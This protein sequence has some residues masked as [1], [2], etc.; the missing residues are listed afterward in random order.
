MAKQVLSGL[1]IAAIILCITSVAFSGNPG[2]KERTPITSR[3]NP[4]QKLSPTPIA[5]QAIS[6]PPD[7]QQLPANVTLYTPP[8]YCEFTDYSGGEF[9]HYA[10]LPDPDIDYYNMR[11]TAAANYT[12]TL[13]TAY[14]AVFPTDFVGNPDLVVKV[15]EDDGFGLPGGELASVTVPYEN[16]PA[17]IGYAIADLSSFNLVFADGENY[18]V[19]ISTSDPSGAN[20]LALLLDDGNNGHGRSGWYDKSSGAFINLADNGFYDYNWGI[21]VDYCCADIPY[22][23]CYRQEY[24]CGPSAYFQHP[25]PYGTDY[26][27]TRFS[28]YGPDTLTALGVALYA[29]G[30]TGSPDVDIFVW[31]S[32][33]GFPD[34]SN[35]IYQTMVPNADI[36]YYPSYNHIDMPGTGLLLP[37]ASDFHIGWETVA[38][39]PGDT[40]A[41]LMDDGTCG[42]FRSSLRYQGAWHLNIDVLENDNNWLIYADICRAIPSSCVRIRNYCDPYYVYSMPSASGDGRIGGF[43][44][45]EPIGDGCHIYDV[46]VAIDNPVYYGYPAGFNFSTTI[47]IREDAGGQPGSVVADTTLQP[48]ELVEYPG[49]IYWEFI[50]ESMS[51]DSPLWVGIKSNAPDP[52]VVNQPDF[53][54][55]G[56]DGSCGGNNAYAYYADG[57][58][59]N[60]SGSNF[61]INA[62]ICCV[63]NPPPV[64]GPADPNWPTAAHDF[65][66]SSAS[67]NSVG[68]ARCRQALAWMHT[69]AA[70]FRYTRP[71]IY[72]GIVLAAYNEKLQAFDI[73]DGALLWTIAGALNGIGA[74]FQNTVTVKDGYVYYGGG[75]ARSISKADVY[76][77]QLIWTRNPIYL[78]HLTGSTINT[79][80][81]LLDCDGTEVLYVT[82]ANGAVY[83][84]DALTG[85]N[86]TGWP[87][88]PVML[89]GDPRQTLSSNGS[90][91]IYAG[92]DGLLG[93]GNG[94]L[95]AIDACTGAIL[96][97]LGE[98]DLAGSYLT[99]TD[100]PGEAFYGPIGVDQDGSIYVQSGFWNDDNNSTPSGA[101]YRITPDGSVFWA[102]AGRL[103]YYAGPV[104]DVNAVYFTTIRY[105]TGE[106]N[107]TAALRK[108]TGAK[109]WESDSF[110]DG[111]GFLE[112]ALSCEVLSPNWLYVTNRSRQMLVINSDDGSVEFEYNYAGGAGPNGCGVAIDSTHVV[113]NN[114]NGDLFCLTIQ[115][116]RPRL[117]ILKFDEYQPVPFFSPASFLVE[118]D[119]IFMNNGCANLTGYVTVDEN[120]PA[121]YAWS[122]DPGRISRM[123]TLASSMVDNT[124]ESVA[125]HL[126]KAQK[127]PA[128][129]LNPDFTASA[130]A[131]DSYSKTAAYGP[132]IWLNAVVTPYFDVAPGGTYSLLYD[133]NGPLVTQGPHRAYLS[134]HSNDQFFLNA[135]DAPVVQ[136]GVIGGCMESDD[137]LYFG[138]GETNQAPVFSTGELGNRNGSCLWGF[139]GDNARYWQGGL[140][141]AAE[142][143]DGHRLAWTTDSWHPADPPD[144]WN[145][146]LPEP[147][148][149][150]RCEPYVTIDPIVLGK[151]SH[152]GGHSY[153]NVYGY[154]SVAA[155]IDSVINFDCYGTGWDWSNVECPYDND[156]TIGLRVRQSM[157]GVIDE[158]ALAN[159][160]IF[161]HDVTNRNASPIVNVGIGAFN[162]YDMSS[163]Y[164]VSDCWLFDSDYSISRGASS[165]AA[166][167][168]TNGAVW[169]NG[170]IPMGVDPMLGATTIDAQQ[171]MWQTDNVWLDSVYYYLSTVRGQTAQIGIDIA[172]PSTTES[173]DRDEWSGYVFRDFAANETYSFGT[174]MFGFA[175]VDVTDHA[176]FRNLA[177]TVNRFAGFDRGDIDNDGAITLADVVA[178]WNMVN[179]GGPG[180]L[181]LHLA[182]VDA[183]GGAPNAADV[184][185]LANF[186]FCSGPAPA[187]DWVLPDICP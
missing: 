183:S 126:V 120:P 142:G 42:T 158:P 13:L 72:D 46:R 118:F 137:I 77:G 18:Y 26:Y 80:A 132:P 113:F 160:V 87:V 107:A 67:Y 7:I 57:S 37:P 52:Y 173:D 84:L 36:Q 53:F 112:G 23:Q 121:A 41:G 90:S 58:W 136:M 43:E 29:D 146:L 85:Q 1:F 94:T 162:D 150:N 168:F 74:D 27:N 116:D 71:I 147:N 186:Y 145:S 151:I 79:T 91:V 66:R 14:V 171:S 148:C 20:V 155:Y 88:N 6:R 175:G 130:Y 166:Y 39:A 12:C 21:G 184:L 56:D 134:I 3:I 140:F 179:A 164:N 108:S 167:D 123:S 156:L 24:D 5:Q 92:T 159:V 16:L 138:S 180:P 10:T 68:D 122:V 169:G 144:F 55:I 187:G 51:F 115:A 133:V 38:N 98:G 114:Y 165:S 70:R 76:T 104:I 47:E 63:Y 28:I 49:F 35:V 128:S 129:E 139:D 127:V 131:K 96:W 45:I 117:R 185:Y 8:Y 48:G 100:N 81:V 83:A 32:S 22:S 103:P 75:S 141:F 2:N 143:A 102:T 64:C 78:T 154:A 95:Y 109:V 124:Y 69:D 50:S 73:D 61:L 182:D 105:W 17:I 59:I 44:K 65:R 110:Y 11:F 119:D 89:D 149:F 172:F 15:W 30:S 157:Y 111:S 82:C 176:F 177:R 161:R 106:R 86:F 170:K 25:S 62:L 97:T 174:Y 19:G 40:L 34:L 181:F 99:G 101:W 163:S 33:G 54:L 60:Y 93:S 9:T 125:K 135:P 4:I 152:D 153:N 178:L 31:G